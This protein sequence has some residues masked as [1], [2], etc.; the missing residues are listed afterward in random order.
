[1]DDISEPST[2]SSNPAE[3]VG[4]FTS[5]MWRLRRE[6]A[7]L[8]GFLPVRR[9]LREGGLSAVAG[10]GHKPTARRA[11][12][13]AARRGLPY[14]A[15]EDGFLRSIAPGAAEPSFSY[16]CDPIGIYYD[17]SGPSALETMVRARA[18]APRAAERDAAQVVEAVAGRGVSKYNLFDEDVGSLSA[19]DPDPAAQVLLVDQ[20]RGDAAVTG[21][22]AGPDAFIAMLVAAA[23]ENPGARLLLKIHPETQMGR[24]AG[25]FDAAALDA[26]AA[27]SAAFA[28]ARDA[29]RVASLTA[30]VSPARLLPRIGRVYVVSSLLGFEALI[31]GRPVVCFGRSFYAGWGLTDD[32]APTVSRRGPA[33]LAALVAAAYRDYTAYFAPGTRE[34]CPFET[35]ADH[36]ARGAR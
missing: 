15:I 34:R 29:G 7:M 3:K 32:R 9:C 22:G 21:A 11:R 16:V 8:T 18:A 24:R 33:P 5:G 10:W 31:C 12:A 26:A 36:L 2:A 17:A 23:E 4:V 25:Y 28:A 19:L 30:R 13:V 35:V 14:F 6:V 1:M 20:T 27:R